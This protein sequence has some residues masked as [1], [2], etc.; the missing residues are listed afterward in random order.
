[1]SPSTAQKLL[2]VLTDAEFQY[3][4]NRVPHAVYIKRQIPRYVGE[5]RRELRRVAALGP[6]AEKFV[7]LFIEEMNEGNEPEKTV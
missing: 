1:M 2:K 4:F 3:Q 5:T 7:G 6:N